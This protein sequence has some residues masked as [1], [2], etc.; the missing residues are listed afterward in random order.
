ML[1][2][3]PSSGCLSPLIDTY[4]RMLILVTI[5]REHPYVVDVFHVSGGSLHDYMLH[6]SVD[7]AQRVEVD[8]DLA[9]ARARFMEG[10]GR[11]DASRPTYELFSSVRG[12]RTEG[13]W[14]AFFVYPSRPD[15]GARVHVLGGPT[16]R[17]TRRR[18]PRADAPP[19]VRAPRSTTPGRLWC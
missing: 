17:F 5:D 18:R 16:R 8:L 11:I 13:G 10:L 6:G 15:V 14:R 1:A 7:H 3:T 2:A 12:A 9:D 19:G 4:R